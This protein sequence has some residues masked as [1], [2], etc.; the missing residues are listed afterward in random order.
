MCGSSHGAGGKHTATTRPC[1][2]TSAAIQVTKL[3]EQEEEAAMQGAPFVVPCVAPLVALHHTGRCE[4]E[5]AL[6]RA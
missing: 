3:G 1:L 5:G 2:P 4:Q 6:P